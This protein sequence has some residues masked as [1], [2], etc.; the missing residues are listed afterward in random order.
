MASPE[1]KENN[2]SNAT[3][4][5][6]ARSV[7]ETRYH[8][9]AKERELCVDKIFYDGHDLQELDPNLVVLSRET[10]EHPR[11]WPRRKKWTVTFITGVYCFLAPFT[12]TIFAP[13]LKSMMADLGET[14]PIKGALQ[15]SIFLLSFALAPIFL[16]PLSEIYGRRIVLQCG[17][18]FFA[19]FCLGGGFAKTTAQ[20]AVCRFFSGVGGSASL[21]VYGGILTDMWDFADRA[22]AS[23]MLGSALL[24]GPIL[25]PSCG[26]WM[27]E[28]ASWRWT[29]WVP[30]MAAVALD[31]MALLLFHETYIPTILQN[32]VQ[33]VKKEYPS[34][35]WYT[36]LDLR[37]RDT[38]KGK[39]ST[40]I[41]SAIRPL[42]YVTLDPALFLQSLYYAF[43]FGVL[44]L[45]I[46]TFERVFGG[47]YGHS[48]GIVG[49]DLMSEGIGALIGMQG[50]AV[51][52]QYIYKREINKNKE[53]KPE[54]RLISAFPGAFCASAGLFL[55]GFSVLKTH[56][57][58]PLVGVAVF[59]VG[60][61][62]TFLA[63]QLYIIDCFEYPA[64]AMAGLS[65]LRCLFAAVFPLFGDR[66]FECLG[67]DWGVG[68][69]AFLSVGLGA[70]FLLALYFY[71]PQLRA[72]GK[73]NRAKFLG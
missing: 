28:R 37:P 42:I 70:P 64:S 58:V 73:K 30:A 11:A 36:V 5:D 15:V 57:M 52:V 48:P 55:Y 67:V 68:L 12:S 18:L 59:T 2:D 29:C 51:I 6:A 65:V 3:A 61:A 27:S 21:S 38:S 16:A 32:K 53:Y 34:Q 4:V 33:R 39:A 8:D 17:N 35:A 50:S 69:L 56:F 19:A 60:M 66:L 22:R 46:T 23:A 43:I 14:D 13:S 10:N 31:L 62:N 63:I 72:V 20:L 41:E 26:G 49:M 47:G 24:L 40:I 44:Y 25:G 45:V 54:T 7:V 1:R 9:L 71:G